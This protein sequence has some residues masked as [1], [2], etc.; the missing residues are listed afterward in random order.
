MACSIALGQNIV[1]V[2][3]S[4]HH[5][6]LFATVLKAVVHRMVR[7]PTF[8]VVVVLITAFFTAGMGR[9]FGGEIGSSRAEVALRVGYCT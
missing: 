9:G 4:S 6:P 7:P 8:D 3:M 5:V 2:V 1:T